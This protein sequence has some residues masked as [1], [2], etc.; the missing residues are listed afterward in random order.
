MKQKNIKDIMSEPDN[1]F[2][3]RQ[4]LERGNAFRNGYIALA[5]AMLVCYFVKD[6]FEVNLVDDSSILLVCL[7]VSAVVFAVT[8]IVKD[9]Y[10]GIHEGRNLMVIT[11]M[12]AVGCFM[13][14][15]EIIKAVRGTFA[16]YSTAGVLISAV[17]MLTICIVYWVK[18]RRDKKQDSVTEKP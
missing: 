2:D 12:G 3:E 15:V 17:G 11:V 13:L 5:A 18:R 14:V 1:R 6:C 8:M 16:F 7:W 10:D 4:V 9:A